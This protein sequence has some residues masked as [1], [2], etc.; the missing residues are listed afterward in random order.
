MSVIVNDFEKIFYF[1]QK[2]LSLKEFV[3]FSK[4][5]DNAGYTIN[6]HLTNGKAIISYEKPSIKQIIQR[7]FTK[8]NN[9]RLNLEFWQIQIYKT[10]LR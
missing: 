9:T 5:L 2:K 3:N 8:L 7:F 6:I 1:G 4:Q 10:C